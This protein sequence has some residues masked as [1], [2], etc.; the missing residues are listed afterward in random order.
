MVHRVR[1]PKVKTI[2]VTFD[3]RELESTTIDFNDDKVL[4]IIM[5]QKM[6]LSI[7]DIDL[8]G[9]K[10]DIS[11]KNRDVVIDFFK[12]SYYHL[13]KNSI[14]ERLNNMFYFFKLFL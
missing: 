4:D 13:Y 3:I 6:Y 2:Y 14:R 5:S 7:F 9:L 1:D 8:R 11:I 10:Y 12:D